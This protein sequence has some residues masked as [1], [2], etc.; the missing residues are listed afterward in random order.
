MM[1]RPSI[2]GMG[3]QQPISSTIR[4]SPSRAGLSNGLQT[5]GCSIRRESAYCLN[6]TL[7]VARENQPGKLNPPQASAG[8]GP[9][10]ERS[11][12]LHHVH[13]EPPSGRTEFS[14]IWSEGGRPLRR[15]SW[16]ARLTLP[17]IALTRQPSQTAFCRLVVD[18]LRAGVRTF[19]VAGSMSHV[20][21][22]SSFE[23]A[24]PQQPLPRPNVPVRQIH[25]AC[26]AEDQHQ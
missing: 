20:H 9:S 24:A 19:R 15:P 11:S 16:D 14:P 7:F 21:A 4:F 17:L 5:A 25:S 23:N 22:R 6:P 2:S 1:G 10:E 13:K 12:Q 3:V 18:R 8:H 26:R